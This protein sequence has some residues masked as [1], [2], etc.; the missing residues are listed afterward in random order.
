MSVEDPAAVDAGGVRSLTLKRIALAAAT[1]FAAINIWT[2]CPLLALWVAAQASGEHRITMAALGVFVIVVALLEGVMIIA[3]AWLHNT[4]DELTRRKRVER[5]PPWLRAMSEESERH[6][7]QRFG[8]SLPE[9]IVMVIVYVA[10]I[11]FAVWYVFFA[12]AT[13]NLHCIAQ[14]GC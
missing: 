14:G 10:V 6:V 1:A 11:A 4:Y 2:G 7:S 8:I 12:S 3:L 13:S 9:R 5:R